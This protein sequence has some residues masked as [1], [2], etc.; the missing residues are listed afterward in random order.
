VWY[1]EPMKKYLILLAVGALAGMAMGAW[2]GPGLIGWWFA[3]P[4]QNRVLTCDREVSWALQS[5]VKVLTASAVGFAVLFAVAG[6]IIGL[7][8]RNRAAR[9]AAA[10]PP[11]PSA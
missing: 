1:K 6:G 8:L 2:L 3:P 7:A 9:K 10:T 11:S 4:V 5:L